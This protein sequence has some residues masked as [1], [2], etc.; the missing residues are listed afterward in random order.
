MDL[1]GTLYKRAIGYEYTDE[2][3]HIEDGGKGKVP[4]KRIVKTKEYIPAHKYCAVY[5]L[6]ILVDNFSDKSYELQLL[7]QHMLLN[8][9][10]WDTDVE[11][12]NN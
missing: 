4:K 5:F 1:I 7:E 6:T 8:K 12:T 3:K 10:G 9:E 2:L 11:N